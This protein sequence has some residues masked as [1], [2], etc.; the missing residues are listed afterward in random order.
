MSLGF[1]FARLSSSLIIS[2]SPL[3]SFLKVVKRLKGLKYVIIHIYIYKVNIYAYKR[4]SEI[5]NP[6][7]PANSLRR[8]TNW[9]ISL[10]MDCGQAMESFKK[11]EKFFFN[12]ATIN[13]E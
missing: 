4:G 10:S 2:E 7:F 8:L 13:R 12:S 11:L 1:I 5:E 6:M 3:K 9:F